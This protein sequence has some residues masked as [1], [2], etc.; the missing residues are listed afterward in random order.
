MAK[1]SSTGTILDFCCL[2]SVI[3]R[4]VQ[5]PVKYKVIETI[6][7]AA[8]H[9]HP[10]A[11]VCCYRTSAKDEVVVLSQAATVLVSKTDGS[12]PNSQAGSTCVV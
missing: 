1:L 6:F 9:G 12:K 3:L 7:E 11:V 2:T 10:H 4:F 5:Q 8:S